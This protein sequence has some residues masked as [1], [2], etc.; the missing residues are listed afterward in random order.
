MTDAGLGDDWKVKLRYGRISTPFQHYAIIADGTAG[1]LA[2]GF[3]CRPGPAMMAMKGW[4]TDIDEAGD[5]IRY[6]SEKVGFSIT[7]RIQIYQAELDEPPRDKPFAY[8]ISFVPYSDGDDS[9]E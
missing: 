7:G 1:Q 3:E 8:N 4:A 9:D 5:M 6:V 2:D